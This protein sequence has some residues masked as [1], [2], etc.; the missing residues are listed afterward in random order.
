MHCSIVLCADPSL[1]VVCVFIARSTFLVVVFQYRPLIW[2][3]TH[4]YVLV[5]R[6]E[7][8]TDPNLVEE[9]P[10]C[11]RNVVFYGYVRGTHLKPSMKVHLIG[12]GDFGMESVSALPDP[13]PLPDKE[14]EQKV[15]MTLLSCI[16]I[17]CTAADLVG[18]LRT[19][20]LTSSLSD[21][22]SADPQKEGRVALCPSVQCRRSLV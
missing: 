8:I 6:H 11:D 21:S 2:R 4:P 18:C 15:G 10:D 9:D 7:D 16:C 1:I 14:S 19:G 3:N 22:L 20:I 17:P 13:L 5:D 12:V